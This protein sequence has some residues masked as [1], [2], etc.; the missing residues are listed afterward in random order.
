MTY[1]DFEDSRFLHD[2]IESILAFYE[3][4]VIDPVGGFFQH[5]ADDGRVYDSETAIW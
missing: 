1:P 2:H 4:N 3:P 5:F